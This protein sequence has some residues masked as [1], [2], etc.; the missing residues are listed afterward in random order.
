MNSDSSFSSERQS[1]GTAAPEP[2]VKEQAERRLPST[3]CSALLVEFLGPRFTI[4]YQPTRNICDGR[5]LSHSRQSA[6]LAGS[7]SSQLRRLLEDCLDQV[8]CRYLATL[9]KNCRHNPTLP[10]L[11]SVAR[12]WQSDGSPEPISWL[13]KVRWDI[14]PSVMYFLGLPFVEGVQY[15]RHDGFDAFMPN[16]VPRLPAFENTIS[17]ER[18]SDGTAKG[19][20]H[21]RSVPDLKS[22]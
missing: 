4:R 16:V 15:V 22:E 5:C 6:E 21:A 13:H 18:R 3:A 10:V 12:R 9:S 20:C 2:E 14:D 11:Q 8:E 1:D 7:G 19:G 17:A